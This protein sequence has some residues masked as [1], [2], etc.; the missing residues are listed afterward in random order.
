MVYNWDSRVEHKN[1][2]S[3]SKY[4]QQIKILS[5]KIHWWTILTEL[6]AYFP[7]DDF[8]IL[9][10]KILLYDSLFHSLP[11][12]TRKK[13]HSKETN[14]CLKVQRYQVIYKEWNIYHLFTQYLHK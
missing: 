11:S 8:L 2:S 13:Q 12:Y 14:N 10:K 1:L 6:L 7:Q 5:Q 4:K 9:W 3:Y